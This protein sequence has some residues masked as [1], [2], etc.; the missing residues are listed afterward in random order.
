MRLLVTG[1]AGF[2]GGNFVHLTVKERPEARIVVLDAMTY[3]GN[4][5]SLDGLGEHV[6]LVR[7]DIADAALVDRLVAA[8]DL[9]V[10]F[11]A[12][13][14][15]DNSLAE[16]WP[17]VQTN[18]VGTFTILEAVRKHDKRLHHVST[19]EVFHLVAV[20]YDTDALDLAANR[21]TLRRRTGGKD[22][23]WH[24]KL[25]D[26]ADRRAAL[27]AHAAHLTARQ[28]QHGV[29]AVLADELDRRAGAA[30]GA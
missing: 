11:A 30:A 14:H 20:Y 22:D 9:V 6:E 25:P 8:S 10:H 4:E 27:E 19:D 26:G 28:A 13:S 1:G 12:E 3:A 18:I 23:G 16:P 15:N 21:I 7:G 29:L 5:G 17:F 24:L 2:I